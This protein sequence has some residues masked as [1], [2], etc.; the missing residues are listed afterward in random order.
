MYNLQILLNYII[1]NSKYI[2]YFTTLGAAIGPINGEKIIPNRDIYRTRAK[3]ISNEIEE[4]KK[5]RMHE[6]NSANPLS[7]IHMGIDIGSHNNLKRSV[8]FMGGQLVNTHSVGWTYELIN[9]GFKKFAHCTLAQF[10]G[11][12]HGQKSDITPQEI[13]QLIANI[14]KRMAQEKKKELMKEIRKLEQNKAAQD[15][16]KKQKQQI[17]QLQK[18]IGM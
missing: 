8:L 18:T 15:E 10:R 1:H 14:A 17:K 4:K 5:K 11:I 2:Q 7:M 9:L 6:L 13:N 12:L 16:I 3:M